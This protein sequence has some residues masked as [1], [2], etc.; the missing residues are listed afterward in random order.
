MNPL[1][2]LTLIRSP[3][4]RDFAVVIIIL[5]GLGFVFYAGEQRKQA[6]WDLDKVR[7]QRE[8]DALKI[9]QGEV[10][11][12]EVIKYVD[13]VKVVE[14]KTKTIVEY[15]DKYIT[16]DSNKNCIVPNNV[17]TI[18]DAAARNTPIPIGVKV[19]DTGTTP[20]IPH[21]EIPK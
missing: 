17:I 2:L 11:I 16:V 18:L 20:K 15:V 7:V 3:I 21:V 6:E 13:R 4:F 5:I 1:A 19:P 10:T 14:G 8:I 12:K 9:K